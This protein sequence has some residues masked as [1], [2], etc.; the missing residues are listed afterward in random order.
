MCGVLCIIG[1]AVKFYAFHIVYKCALIIITIG[2]WSKT[3]VRYMLYMP[4]L[5]LYHQPAYV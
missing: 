5:A 2:V 4:M 1:C 3:S